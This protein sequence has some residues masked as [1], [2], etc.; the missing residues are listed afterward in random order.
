MAGKKNTLF[1]L[2]L[3]LN[4]RD[5]LR[6]ISKESGYSM[7][8]ITRTCLNFGLA[9]FR[10]GN[11][12]QVKELLLDCTGNDRDLYKRGLEIMRVERN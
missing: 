1:T 2:M 11:E 7:A 9:L 10:T 3:D 4:T 6:S 8:T 5:F 12:T